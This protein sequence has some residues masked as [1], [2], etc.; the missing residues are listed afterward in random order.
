MKNGLIT[1]G[2]VLAFIAGYFAGNNFDIV[3]KDGS[4]PKAAKAA[5]VAKQDEKVPSDFTKG[6]VP[7][8]Q[9]MKANKPA[10]VFFYVDWCGYCKRFAPLMPDLKKKYNGK[11]NMVM[12]N[13]EDA[14]NGDILKNYQINGYPT[15]YLVNP[16]TG[17]SE[18]IE[19]TNYYPIENIEAY[20]DNYL[21]K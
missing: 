13:C 10:M 15:I 12:V 18:Y 2:I 6:L 16:K 19:S 20:I 3:P 11:I 21:K 7:Y 17:A 14:K 5:P 9:A 8:E 4:A 1:V